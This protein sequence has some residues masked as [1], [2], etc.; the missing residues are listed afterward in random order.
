MKEYICKEKLSGGK[1]RIKIIGKIGRKRIK[2]EHVGVAHN[3]EELKMYLILARERL[4]DPRQCELNLYGEES[5]EE[6][7]ITQNRAYSKYLY[8]KIS[9]VY[10]KLKFSEIGDEIF[11]DLTIARIIEPGSK[12]DTIRILSGL[13]LRAPTLKGIRCSLKRVQKEEYRWEITKKCCEFIGLKEGMLLLYDVT[14]LH[15]EI[16]KEDG[17]RK[18]GYSKERRLEPQIVIGLVVDKRGFPLSI[19]S[20]EGNKAETKT[21]VPVLKGFK[22]E[23]G[24]EEIT[25][26]A[27][28]GILSAD[29][30][31]KL[32]EEG[33]KF[34][35]GSRNYKTPYEIA[36]YHYKGK[37]A[38]KRQAN[39]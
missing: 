36:E 31:D 38:I 16:D 3:E 32:E 14:T 11:R 28:A 2:V 15:F 18:R 10:D 5:K 19:N 24:I 25:V 1:T 21:L 27:D 9:E 17:Y 34:V 33:F 13:G 26:V 4:K 12:K 35:V 37:E 39:I 6:L 22:R 8:D 30:L 29:N 20:F 23:N 7:L